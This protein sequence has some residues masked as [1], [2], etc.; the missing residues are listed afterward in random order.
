M[1]STLEQAATTDA[2]LSQGYNSRT[3]GQERADGMSDDLCGKLMGCVVEPDDL[4]G[5]PGCQSGQKLVVFNPSL[6][7]LLR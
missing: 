3:R 7:Y 4:F 5:R 1:G 6:P 2:G